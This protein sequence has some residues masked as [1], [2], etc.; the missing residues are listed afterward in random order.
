MNDGDELLGRLQQANQTLLT[1]SGNNLPNQST[2]E[3]GAIDFSTV[4]KTEAEPLDETELPDWKGDAPLDKAVF[5][6]SDMTVTKQPIDES[7]QF[8]IPTAEDKSTATAQMQQFT[9][10][11][12]LPKKE[13]L[14]NQEQLSNQ[15]QLVASPDVTASGDEPT[16]ES[17]ETIT[18]L[19]QADG[20]TRHES[21]KPNVPH[22][23]VSPSPS[24]AISSQPSAHP[25]A[26]TMMMNDVPLTNSSVG[27]AAAAT[28]AESVQSV[29]VMDPKV[30]QASLR[31]SVMLAKEKQS[32]DSEPGREHSFA[33]Q[34]A[35]AA[36]QSS[37]TQPTGLRH[38]PAMVQGQPLPL[39]LN[40]GIV[41]DEMAER[42]QM[43]MSK[44]LKNIDIRL[45]PPELGR[46]HIRMNM[47]GDGAS[48]QFMVANNQA[49][50]AL[51]QSMPRLREML[52]QQGVQLADT[53][54]QQQSAGQQQQYSANGRESGGLA[55]K[56]PLLGDENLESDIK[57]DL[58]VATKRD[59]ISYYA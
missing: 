17:V 59:G 2:Q 47:H 9:R 10:E 36:G 11:S 26:A 37:A 39:A 6:H 19:A 52:A 55:G 27:S 16:V 34:L 33:Q 21:A 46:M 29:P 56:G 32:L 20:H 43:M 45:D 40:K 8:V 42:V 5:A 15:E 41:A 7:E 28:I 54:V 1:T 53:S 58:N 4:S 18:A 22:G 49:R 23:L 38:D 57:L 12:E 25:A 24:A 44:N 14:P 3:E 51:E 50:D 48:V 30:L 35:T 31:G 13:R